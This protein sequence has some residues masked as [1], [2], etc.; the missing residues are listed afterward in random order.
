MSGST[1]H[2]KC[3]VP[4]DAQNRSVVWGFRLWN[5][6]YRQLDG[7]ESRITHETWWDR[8]PCEP[9]AAFC[10]VTRADRKSVAVEVTVE[11]IGCQR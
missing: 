5:K 10:E 8:I 7:E 9:G 6:S 2:V 3:R 11:V 1:V 4:L